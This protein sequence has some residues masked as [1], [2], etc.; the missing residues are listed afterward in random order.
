MTNRRLPAPQAQACGANLY[1][2]C[3]GFSFSTRAN[4]EKTGTRANGF[5]ILRKRF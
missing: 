2:I 1:C 4:T 3:T 5:A